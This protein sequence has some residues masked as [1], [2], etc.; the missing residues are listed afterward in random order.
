MEPPMINLDL[1]KEKHRGRTAVLSLLVPAGLV[2]GLLVFL[3]GVRD[4]A[5][6]AL[7]RLVTLLP[8]SYAFAAGM[9][10]SVNP[11]GVLMLPS[12]VIYQLGEAEGGR[13]H[14]VQR[15]L[16]A[17]GL[18]LVVTTGFTLV[19][20][21]VG[22]IISAGGQWLVSGF[23]VAGLLIGVAMAG[24][25]IWLLIGRGSVGIAAA[26]RVRITPARTLG[27]ML[28]FGAV[29]AIGSL[30]CTL[31]V[32]LVV[33]GSALA[34]GDAGGSLGQFLGYA[35]GMGTVILTATV[36]TA[37]FRGAISRWMDQV[38][39]YVHRFGAMFLIGAGG[40][41]V[42]YWLFIVGIR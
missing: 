24:L 28:L 39:P 25:G 32:F 13:R 7:A 22:A 30:S 33:V 34:S 15:L 37:L 16:Q 14:A 21:L 29:Y 18:A 35:L 36:G 3:V 27:N 40:Y 12:Y 38:T 41:L 8:V 1:T 6:G 31:P 9:V 10:A 23:P 2:L 17:V 4:G 26:G 19:F 11:C 42:V 20:V 5:E